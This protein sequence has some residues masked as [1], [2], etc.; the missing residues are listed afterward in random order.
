MLIAM[1]PF[2][3]S[4]HPILNYKDYKVGGCVR[5]TEDVLVTAARWEDGMGTASFLPC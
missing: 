2:T 1:A 5:D 3:T 4:Y